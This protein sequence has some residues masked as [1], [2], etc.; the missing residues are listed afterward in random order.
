MNEQQFSLQI[1]FLFPLK[2]LIGYFVAHVLTG[3]RAS[4]PANASLYGW[5]RVKVRVCLSNLSF[6]LENGIYIV[7]FLLGLRVISMLFTFL[8]FCS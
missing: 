8:E 5:L 7:H 3:S 1:L 4:L 2:Q 6:K